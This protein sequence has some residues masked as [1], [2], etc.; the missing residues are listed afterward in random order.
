MDDRRKYPRYA[1]KV[2]L[3][4]SLG[5][6][7]MRK[8]VRIETQDVSQGG[9][10]FETGKSLPLAA[11]ARVMVSRLGGELLDSA[12]IRARVA[13]IE[14]LTSSERYRVGIKFEE[15]I[16]VTSAQLEERIEAWKHGA[17]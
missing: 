10:C 16:D 11:Q 6:S 7:L 3:F 5:E 13:H 15:L 2:P 12:Q 8:W 17:R 4:V 1:V 14:P 9:L